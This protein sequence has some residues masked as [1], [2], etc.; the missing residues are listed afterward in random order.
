MATTI[1]E[2]V[3][4]LGMDA[5]KFN[6]AQKAAMAAFKKTQEELAKA[7]TETEAQGKK[8]VEFFVTLKRELLGFFALAAG[9]R[10]L[11]ELVG[12]VINLDAS[13]E[14]LSFSFGASTHEL[15]VWQSAMR[16][17]GGTT[18]DARGAI[19][20]LV[21]AMRD[22]L[23][24]PQQGAPWLATLTRLGVAPQD[25]MNPFKVME[26]IERQAATLKTPDQRADFSA[27]LRTL[28]AMNQNMINLLLDGSK[29]YRDSAEKTFLTTEETG[30]ASKKVIASLALLEDATTGVARVFLDTLIPAMDKLTALL[31]SWLKPGGKE[32]DFEKASSDLGAL[33]EE[34]REGLLTWLHDL[35]FGPSPSQLSTEPANKT[36]IGGGGSGG[37]ETLAGATSYQILEGGQVIGSGTFPVGSRGAAAVS[38][39]R[40][41]RSRSSTTNDHSTA[42]NMNNVNLV[43]PKVTDAASFAKA[44][45]GAVSMHQSNAIPFNSG[46]Q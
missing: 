16:Q 1:D 37:I 41:D 27:L 19:L 34:G 3:V 36:R 18:E 10:G 45:P 12:H 2:L 29:K 11:K 22:F 17:A 28:P 33:A 39:V 25:R 8:L 35:V 43:L 4:V 13:T 32:I 31:P 9:G 21:G 14:R 30:I 24:N 46:P 20:V 5:S 44:L 23:L 6:E 40:N 7:G 38:N 42:I 26:T 15:A